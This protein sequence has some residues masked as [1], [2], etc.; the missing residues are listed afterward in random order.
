MQGFQPLLTNTVG[1]DGGVEGTLIFIQY[2]PPGHIEEVLVE[3]IDEVLPD[4]CLKTKQCDLIGII[5]TS[6]AGSVVGN[7]LG[8]G[9]RVLFCMGR[10]IEVQAKQGIVVDHIISSCSFETVLP[11]RTHREDC[12]YRILCMACQVS[13]V[14]L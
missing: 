9:L 13:F 10:F 2:I 8:Q 6:H 7:H 12:L 11:T 4:E 1:V 14:A 5:Q 3:R